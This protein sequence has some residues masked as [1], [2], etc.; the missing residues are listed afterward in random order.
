MAFGHGTK[1]KLTINSVDYSCYLKETGADLSVDKAETT[2]LCSTAKN[3]IPGLKDGTVPLGGLFD[4]T[5]DAAVDAA[6]TA[7]S[8]TFLYQPQGT[9]SG[10]PRYSGSGFF[11]KYS[12]KTN[13]TDAGSFDG[14]YQ[15][16]NGWTRGTNP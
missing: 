9:T 1:A 5:I 16:S 6:I 14:E 4:P 3:Y 13:T 2:V 10:L 12:L 15:I 7:G 8:V 11:T